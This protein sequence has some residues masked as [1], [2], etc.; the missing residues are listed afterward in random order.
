MLD[1]RWALTTA[2]TT[3]G[4]RRLRRGPRAGRLLRRPRHRARRARPAP[5]VG[6]RC[7]IPLSCRR[8]CAGPASAEQL[9]SSPTTARS[10]MPPRGPGGCC[11][12]SG[13]PDV[14]VLDGG[15]AAWLAA[16][17][18]V[19]TEE[20]GR[21]ATATSSVTPGPLPTL[22]ADGAAALA[23]DGLLLDARAPERYA[24]ETEPIDPV[25][26]HVP[27]AVNS[28]TTAWLAADGTFR[29]DLAE[30]WA[31]SRASAP[32]GDGSTAGGSASTAARASPQP[33]TCWRWP[34]SASTRRSTRAPGASG[35]A[36]RRVPSPPARTGLSALSTCS[37]RGAGC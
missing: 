2:N 33:T 15:Y 37:A 19:S 1:V 17:L 12:G 13:S 8:S 3:A 26:G 6:T 14:R 11:A 27:G 16:G 23:R 5:A 7:P 21:P 32:D 18:P 22:D 28:P 24:G 31:A 9:A 34:S 10:R 35:S 20:P 30:H 36:T 29:R 4:S 25:A